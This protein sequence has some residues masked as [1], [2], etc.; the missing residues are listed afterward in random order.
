MVIEEA[1]V[2]YYGLSLQDVRGK[3][4]YQELVRARQVISYLTVNH[5]SQHQI[6]TALG[7]DRNNIQYGK[8]KCAD[9]MDTEP[10]LRKE[11]A[12]IQ[13][14]LKVPF[15]EI[16]QQAA[17]MIDKL[18]ETKKDEDEKNRNQTDDN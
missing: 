5:G 6:A 7:T 1:V 11:V 3:R 4:R 18:N 17:D 13:L 14:R 9:L 2:S 10:L 15:A 8:T 16:D 12:E